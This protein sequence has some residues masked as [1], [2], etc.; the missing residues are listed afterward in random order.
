MKKELTLS[1]L[2]L[3]LAACG[4]GGDGESQGSSG[5]NSGVTPP[6]PRLS[7]DFVRQSTKCDVRSPDTSAK[8]VLHKIDGSVL[9]VYQPDA[10]GHIDISLPADAAHVSL[11]KTFF[12][13]SLNIETSLEYKGGDLGINVSYDDALDDSCECKSV[14][15]NPTQ[16]A[17]AFPAHQIFFDSKHY[18][19]N[20][21]LTEES[22]YSFCKA[23]DA[24]YPSVDLWVHP[25]VANDTAYGTLLDVNLLDDVL[26]LTE[27]LVSGDE[28]LGVEVNLTASTGH[29]DGAKVYGMTGGGRRHNMS[30]PGA[31][32]LFPGVL[33]HNFVQGSHLEFLERSAEADVVYYSAN[34]LRVADASQPQILALED[35]SQQLLAVIQSFLQG[36]ESESAV[37][38]DLS[39]IGNSRSA[40]VVYFSGHN[41]SWTINAPVTG[42]F[43]DLT[44][45]DEI[46][47]K[48]EASE[49]YGVLFESFGYGQSGGVD[50]LR[51]QWA[52]ESRSGTS[53]RPTFFDNYTSEIIDVSIK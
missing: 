50:E 23:P 47:A 11:I 52:L 37:N 42:T 9:A 39:N 21:P 19:D 51:R 43:P 45:P 32:Y 12:D 6:A 49:P 53:I 22:V 18:L 13:S 14:R 4:G 5:G 26:D 34:R 3:A 20:T 36:F 8:V 31:L 29:F 27:E 40:F 33:T 38:Y 41:M 28:K 10:Q 2:M 35:N 48:I 17:D 15:V 24:Q 30:T 46:L 7:G 16:L 1:L 25:T 44:L